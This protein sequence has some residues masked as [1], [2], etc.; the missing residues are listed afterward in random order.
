M[1]KPSTAAGRT[2]AEGMTMHELYS[3]LRG[4]IL[5]GD[6]APK[7]AF[8]QVKLAERLGVSRTPLREALRLL[9]REGLI[10]TAPNRRAKV[11]E[12]SVNDLDD[13]Y[14]TRIMLEALAISTSVAR[15]TEADLERLAE[16]LREMDRIAEAQDVLA[17]EV[18]HA[19]FHELLI[20]HSGQRMFK[21]ACDLRDHSQRYRTFVLAEPLAW[22]KGADE[23]A[24]IYRAYVERDASRVGDL[25]A[26][27]YA[28]TA[29]TLIARMAPEYDPVF[30]RSA[31]RFAQSAADRH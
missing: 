3:R 9:E 11:V 13:L 2:D 7:G 29:L 20:R 28:R 22:A 8:S 23:H 6:F 4:E 27:H 31:L 1:E 14:G 21:M 26:K 10:E 30:I 25:L 15:A 24:G 18:P 12:I 17:W 16:L 19:E 5:S